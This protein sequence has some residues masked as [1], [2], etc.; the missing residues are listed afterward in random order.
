MK[1]TLKAARVN[2]GYSLA[3]AAET[4]EVDPST[5]CR[6]ERNGSKIPAVSCLKLCEA[7]GVDIKDIKL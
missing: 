7:Y 5:V 6:W 3:Q 1:I 4:T 2:A